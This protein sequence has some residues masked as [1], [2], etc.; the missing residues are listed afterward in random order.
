M[1]FIE[2]KSRDV[3]V[4]VHAFLSSAPVLELRRGMGWI[5]PSSITVFYESPLGG[6]QWRPTVHVGGPVVPPLLSRREGDLYTEC[7]LSE[8]VH[9]AP[10]WVEGF[11]K[12]SEP[13]AAL[14]GG[15]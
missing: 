15:A 10:D 3:I 6:G 4:K 5:R 2:I 14:R 9:R 13:D 7:W 12:L 11:V 8:E 1:P